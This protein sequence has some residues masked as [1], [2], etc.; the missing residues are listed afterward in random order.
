MIFIIIIIIMS[1]IVIQT[2]IKMRTMYRHDIGS[3]NIIL[4]LLVGIL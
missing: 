4:V 2:E 3:E 1:I